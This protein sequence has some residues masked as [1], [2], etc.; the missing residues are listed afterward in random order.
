MI[1]YIVLWP[2]NRRFTYLDL[3][4]AKKSMTNGDKLF[5]VILDSNSLVPISEAGPC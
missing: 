3:E 2:D 1:L 5:K 4:S